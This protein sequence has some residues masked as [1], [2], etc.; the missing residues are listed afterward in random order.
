MNWVSWF[1]Y[2]FTFYEFIPILGLE[3]H[4]LQFNSD[5]LGSF[6]YVLFLN[7]FFFNIQPSTMILI[8]LGFIICFDLFFYGIIIIT[9]P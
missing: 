4:V 6:Y 8:K 2:L 3:S 9:W 5:R 1:I 7:W